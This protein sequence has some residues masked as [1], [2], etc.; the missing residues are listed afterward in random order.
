MWRMLSALVSGNLIGARQPPFDVREGSSQT[1]GKDKEY[2]Q[3][4]SLEIWRYEAPR[5]TDLGG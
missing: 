3:N 2:V 4:F 1:H 5:D